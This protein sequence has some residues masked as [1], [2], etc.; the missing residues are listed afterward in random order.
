MHF[1]Q[2][3]DA[4]VAKLDFEYEIVG[5]GVGA[6]NA[7]FY[8]GTIEHAANLN[9]KGIVPFVEEVQKR[10]DMPVYM[11]NDASA[12]AIGEMVFGEAQNMKDFM[13]ITLGTGLGSGIVCNGKLVYGY[14]SQAGELGHVV[15]DRNGRWTG[16]GTQRRS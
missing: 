1:K 4:I 8:R 16:L 7:N 15:I 2:N 5:M 13:V 11:T 6:P 10:Y 3:I 12:A 9:W 14:D